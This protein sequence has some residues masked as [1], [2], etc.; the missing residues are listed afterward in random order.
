MQLQI[1]RGPTTLLTK[2]IHVFGDRHRPDAPPAPFVRMPLT[3][4]RTAKSA[5]NPV[6]I[7]PS[8]ALPNLVDAAGSGAAIAF[9]PIASIWPSRRAKLGTVARKSIESEPIVLPLGFDFSY[10]QAS[11]EDQRL[12]RMT[13]GEWVVL[14]GMHPLLPRVQFKLPGCMLL[15]R[16]VT[17]SGEPKTPQTL[18]PDRLVIDTDRQQATLTYRGGIAGDWSALGDHRIE[19]GLARDEETVGFPD[20]TDPATRRGRARSPETTPAETPSLGETIVAPLAQQSAPALPFAQRAE[21]PVAPAF[22]VPTAPAPPPSVPDAPAPV[23]P[24]APAPPPAAMKMMGTMALDL[25][26]IRAVAVPFAGAATPSTEPKQTSREG[27]PFAALSDEETRDGKPAETIRSALREVPPFFVDTAIAVHAFAWQ[28]RPPQESLVVIAKATFDLRD[29]AAAVLSEEAAMLSGDVFADDDLGGE[30]QAASDYAILKREVDVLVHGTAYPGAPEARAGHVALRVRG[31]G[32][33]IERSLAVLGDRT[34]QGGALDL[35]P[36]A[37]RPFDAMPLSW[38]RAFGGGDHPENPVGV[39]YR[40]AP[41]RDGLRRLPNFEIPGKLIASPSDA[42]TPAGLGPLN[43]VWRAR[44]SMI[45]TYDAVWFRTRWPYFA[46]DLDVAFFQAA[47]KGQRLANANGDEHYELTGL[48]P[49]QSTLRGRLGEVRARAFAERRGEGAAGFREIALK[50]DT[51]TFRPEQGKAE[52]VWRGLLDVSDDDAPEIEFLFATIEPLAGPRLTL[53]EARSRALAVA[54]PK[55]EP[56]EDIVDQPGDPVAP[57][58][59]DPEDAA[60]LAKIEAAVAAREAEVGAAP[61][62]PEAEADLPPPDPEAVAAVMRESGATEEEIAELTAALNPKEATEPPP[63]H[64]DL[65]ALV[66]ARVQAGEPLSGMDLRGADLSELDLHGQTFDGSDLSAA[67]LDRADLRGANA[68]GARLAGASLKDAKLDE[69]NLAGCDLDSAILDGATLTRAILDA[70][71]ARD[72]HAE[73]A[74]LTGAHLDGAV[75]AGAFLTSAKFDGA[76]LISADLTGACIDRATF[77]A[78]TMTSVKLYDVHGEGASFDRADLTN[79]RCESAMFV[80]GSFR[81]ITADESI[82]EGADLRGASFEGAT[83][84]AASF[85]RAKAEKAVFNGADLEN[86]RMRRSKLAGALFVAAN[87]MEAK[88]DKANLENADLRSANLHAATLTKAWLKGA[89]LDNAITTYSDLDK[90][91]P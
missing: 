67:C 40:G 60:L 71:E 79:A 41:A 82:W 68:E 87:L 61:D 5:T 17:P 20:A 25:E 50:L 56:E 45:G 55:E 15:A 19:V 39:G 70:I 51:I 31:A 37:P 52:L 63:P 46:E 78:A 54:T 42:P 64:V 26:A 80:K 88:L 73:K 4:E 36:S 53:E 29:G 38:T 32:G 66:E 16:L 84:R 57:T 2:R 22:V 76:S 48:H 6:G 14:D 47:P 34:W 43:P 23:A 58:P 10:F 81:W 77:S 24:V 35:L 33:T 75:L 28:V 49:T 74:D 7:D 89:K 59:E 27:L 21:A 9:G 30:L 13:G 91:Q 3:W 18:L 85:L 72:I 44:W 83:L 86:A 62:S 8:R 12:D 65:R 11:P 1:G 90:R 69:A